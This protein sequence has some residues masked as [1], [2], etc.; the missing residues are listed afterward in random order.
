MTAPTTQNDP[1]SSAVSNAAAFEM[2]AY[3]ADCR[4]LTLPTRPAKALRPALCIGTCLALGGN[5]DGV[6]PSAAAF[7][8]QPR[9]GRV[10]R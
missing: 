7:E 9:A 2:D 3:L 1:G 10:I 6:L 5:L 8:L 4:E